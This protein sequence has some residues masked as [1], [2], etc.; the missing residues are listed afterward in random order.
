MKVC[1]GSAG[2]FHTFDLARQMERL[3]RLETLYTAYPRWKVN[4]L[5]REKVET[6][7]WVMAPAAG[8]A[9]L[10]RTRIP[11]EID[12]VI[13]DSF[14]R[15]MTG[16][17][18]EC[19]VFHCLSSFG[20]RA[21][22]A[23]KDRYTALTVCDRGS[24]HIMH[25]DEILAEE[26]ALWRIPYEHINRRILDWELEEY[27]ECDLI[28]VPSD[29]AY[30]SFIEQG[31][32]EAKLRKVSYGVDLR[33]FRRIPKEDAIFRVIY[34]GALSLRKGLPYLLEAARHLCALRLELWLI[35]DA[36][37]EIKPFLAKYEGLFRYSG[38]VPR[39]ELYRY[40]SEGSVFVL[41]S[42][43]EGLALVQAQAMACGLPVIATTNTGAEDIYDDGVEGFIVPI[44]NPEAIR[45][46]ILHLYEHPDIR[47]EMAQAAL[48]RVRALG[49]WDGYGDRMLGVYQSTLS[50]RGIPAQKAS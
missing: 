26:H 3:G 46:R 7:P 34:V 35:G 38:A 49:G 18:R 6:F 4:G 5:P 1:I 33:A 8:L 11:R 19:D 30:R 22:Q 17:L 42:L 10:T 9:R 23:A 41:P 27:D 44:R 48:K 36:L 28:V 12:W 39:T 2:R 29:F 47:D 16:C 40:Y 13:H 50:Y 32:P 37:P 21:H 24:S 25:Q 20:R 43:E 45:E 15:W 31:V 14:D